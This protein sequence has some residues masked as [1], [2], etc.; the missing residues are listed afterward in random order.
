ML[1]RSFLEGSE[2]GTET[3]PNKEPKMR[4]LGRPKTS[5]SS[6]RSFKIKVLGRAEK[7]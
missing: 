7:E 4:A 6:V 3:E 1:K 2:I 5:T